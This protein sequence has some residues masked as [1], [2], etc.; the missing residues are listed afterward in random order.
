MNSEQFKEIINLISHGSRKNFE[1]KTGMAPSTISAA[2]LA[3][4]SKRIDRLLKAQFPE[5]FKLAMEV[6]TTP[7]ATPAVPSYFK[8]Y[9]TFRQTLFL[10]DTTVEEFA[11]KIGYS[12]AYL[13]Q[14]I[15]QPVRFKDEFK[16][17]FEKGMKE[18]RVARVGNP[19]S[20]SKK[21]Q[22]KDDLDV[23]LS[24]LDEDYKQERKPSSNESPYKW[25]TIA[26]SLL[27]LVQ[28]VIGVVNI[29]IFIN[30]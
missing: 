21:I 3:G 19:F 24:S 5:E 26:L 23:F 27:V 13:K 9:W 7:P 2:T 28:V 14:V 1:R 18:L 15:R 22:L 30:R 10:Y 11:K 20:E 16:E 8:S 25:P 29:I 4:T 17:R 12:I 6:K